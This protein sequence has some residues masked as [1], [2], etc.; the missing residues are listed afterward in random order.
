[1]GFLPAPYIGSLRCQQHAIEG[2]IPSLLDH[3][4]AQFG[5]RV[6]LIE[7]GFTRT[8]FAHNGQTATQLLEAYSRERCLALEA[9]NHAISNGDDP[10]DGC[11][12]CGQVTQ[13]GTALAISSWQGGQRCLIACL[14][15]WAPSKLLDK[16]VAE[17]V[18]TVC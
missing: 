15:K 9:I 16:G 12:G 2:N 10:A 3:E 13:R 5:I 1:M 14:K 7:P 18:W 6:S 17:A 11:L 4:P 8:G